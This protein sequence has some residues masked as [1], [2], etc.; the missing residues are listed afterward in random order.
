MMLCLALETFSLSLS[1]SGRQ[2]RRPS[3]SRSPNKSRATNIYR[4]ASSS[5]ET[6]SGTNEN[7]LPDLSHGGYQDLDD[8]DNPSENIIPTHDPFKLL[9]NLKRLEPY[10]DPNVNQNVTA[11]V[12]KSAYLNCVV[13]NLGNKTVECNP[14]NIP[15]R[16]K[17][18]LF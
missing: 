2:S 18:R 7:Y 8:I 4:K 11:L 15:F 10:F 9:T 13:K 3:S 16:L 17:F 6:S 1:C 5:P 12:G 14:F